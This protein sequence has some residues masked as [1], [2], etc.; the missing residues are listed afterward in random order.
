M[1]IG[2]R[3]IETSIILQLDRKFFNVHIFVLANFLRKLVENENIEHST[4]KPDTHETLSNSYERLDR[5]VPMLGNHVATRDED[6]VQKMI[7]EKNRKVY[8]ASE[9]KNPALRFRIFPVVF[10]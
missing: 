7:F 4:P 10:E 5:S 6:N 8:P 2:L 9:F 1:V 3:Q